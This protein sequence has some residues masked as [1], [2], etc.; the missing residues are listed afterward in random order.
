LLPTI[1]ARP[2]AQS[3]VAVWFERRKP[4]VLAEVGALAEV[5]IAAPLEAKISSACI[6]TLIMDEARCRHVPVDSLSTV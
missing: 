4:A 1:A 6:D 5:V 2:P 3:V